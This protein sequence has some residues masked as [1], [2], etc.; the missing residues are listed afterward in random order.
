MN[1]IIKLINKGLINETHKKVV[2]YNEEEKYQIK[3]TKRTRCEKPKY[4]K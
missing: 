4:T 3:N 2:E 1:I